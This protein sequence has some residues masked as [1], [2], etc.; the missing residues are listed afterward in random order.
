MPLNYEK[1][2]PVKYKINTPSE[3]FV[4]FTENY[5]K[6]WQL[7]Y[8]KPKLEAVNVYEFKGENALEYKRFKL[9]LLSYVISALALIFLIIKLKYSK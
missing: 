8:Q 9:Y 3:K 2:S 7:G 6:N 4:I 1:L 5:N